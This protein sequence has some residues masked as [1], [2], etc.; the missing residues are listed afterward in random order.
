MVV[1]ASSGSKPVAQVVGIFG[2]AVGGLKTV[3]A[4]DCGV[5]GWR[6]EEGQVRRSVTDTG[7]CC[8]REGGLSG[9]CAGVHDVSAGRSSPAGLRA[10]AGVLLLRQS[11]LGGE[12]AGNVWRDR[13]LIWE[14]ESAGIRSS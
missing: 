12:V 2:V 4:D 9:T 11:S 14:N 3:R 8:Q 7:S 6:G 10:D 13:R 5:E 1:C